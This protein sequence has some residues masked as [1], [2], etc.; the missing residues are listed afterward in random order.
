MELNSETNTT[1]KNKAGGADDERA[2]KSQDMGVGW[3]RQ[4]K[5]NKRECELCKGA[6]CHMHKWAN[7]QLASYKT[8]ICIGSR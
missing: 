1:M 5:H 8:R 6:P 3:A 4:E 2:H 7:R